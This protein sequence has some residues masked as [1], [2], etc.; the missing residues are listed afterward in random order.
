MLQRLRAQLRRRFR[1]LQRTALPI[2]QAGIAAGGAWLV[3]TDL[4][5]HTQ[6]FFA[7]AAAVTCIGVALGQKL[8][9][10][11]ELVV[12]VSVGVGVGDVLISR[13]GTGTWQIV[14][15]VV[16]AMAAAVLLD[17]GAVI[18]LQAGTSAV[19]IATLA[20]PTTTGGFDRMIDALIGGALGLIAIA[21][22]P[23]DPLNLAHRHGRVVLGELA[24]VLRAIGE[25]V[26]ERDTVAAAAA[27]SRA[28]ASQKAIDEF[29]TALV[30]S[31]EVTTIAPIRWRNRSQLDR[32]R[33]ASGPVDL[34][35]RN[36]RVLARRALAVLRDGEEPPSKL[37]YVLDGLANAVDALRDELA[38][39]VDPVRTRALLRTTA[40]ETDQLLVDDGFSVRVMIAQL[41]SIVVDLLVAA[42]VSRADALS[43]LPPL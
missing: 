19:L 24:G 41:R 14:L 42:G 29:K 28:R 36:T 9:R 12:G 16:L 34:A 6:P 18:A 33:A 27:L 20:P 3:A 35:V 21:L 25:A 43:A 7:P 15:V 32:Y 5:G 1:R 26:P 8:R 2:A 38:R 13:I 22:F 31:A 39:G 23:P 37:P 11:I 17:G 30:T 4:V 10:V 40:A